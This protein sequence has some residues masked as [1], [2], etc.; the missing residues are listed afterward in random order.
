MYF[1]SNEFDSILCLQMDLSDIVL[2][3]QVPQ[4][5]HH[6]FHHKLERRHGFQRSHSQAQVINT[7]RKDTIPRQ[8]I[9]INTKAFGD[10]A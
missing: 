9:N 2:Y 5:K 3:L 8:N 4:Y 7:K 6:Q 10:I 1:S